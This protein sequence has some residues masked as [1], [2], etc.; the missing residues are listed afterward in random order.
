MKEI[1]MIGTGGFSAE[2]TEYIEDNNRQ[3]DQQI[4]IMGYFDFDESNYLQYTYN[5]P[6]LGF[7]KDYNFSPEDSVI[8]AVGDVEKRA[9]IIS[10]FKEININI[11]GFIHHT[12]MIAKTA[13]L[14]TG[15]IICPYVII[16]PNTIFGDNN[17]INFYSSVPHDCLMGDCNVLSPNIQITG[18]TKIGNSNFFGVSSGTKPSIEIGD[19]NKVQAGLIIDKNILDKSIVF[20]IEKVK[21][22]KLYK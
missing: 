16:G 2:L 14:G 5:A 10:Y 3:E 4:K 13:K 15:N 9:K 20:K 19:D 21:S 17:L 1:Y 7:E 11:E 6:Y 8:I 22:M 18:Y 12:A